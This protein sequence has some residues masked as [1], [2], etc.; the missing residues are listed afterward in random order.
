M[1]SNQFLPVH[2]H[3]RASSGL[4]RRMAI[5][6]GE[7]DQDREKKRER[8]SG[9]TRDGEKGEEEGAKRQEVGCWS[10]AGESRGNEERDK[11]EN[12]GEMERA[13]FLSDRATCPV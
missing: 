13:K 8:S 11:R 6:Q 12:E 2:A 7:G 1:P 3:C 9:R 10:Y 5:R 4:D